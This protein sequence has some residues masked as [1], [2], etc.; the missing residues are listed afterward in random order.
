MG[1]RL[2]NKKQTTSPETCREKSCQ[3]PS[4]RKHHSGNGQ[5]KSRPEDGDQLRGDKNRGGSREKPERRDGT[6]TV[7]V[8]WRCRLSRKKRGPGET[9]RRTRPDPTGTEIRKLSRRSQSSSVQKLGHTDGV[10]GG[11]E[12]GTRIDRTTCVLS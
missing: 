1:E 10:Q 9:P 5:K 12:G 4:R 7:H 6:E 2:L 8:H 11:K 3:K